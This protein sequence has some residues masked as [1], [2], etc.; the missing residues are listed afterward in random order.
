MQQAEPNKRI[1]YFTTEYPH[2]SHTFI[3]REIVG[4]ETRGYAIERFA[5]KPGEAGV[6]HAD[7]A[8]RD[9]TTYLL[10]QSPARIVAL[11]GKGLALAGLSIL[12]TLMEVLKLARA[13]DRGLARHIAYLGEALLLR[14]LCREKAVPHLHVHFGTNAATIAYFARLMGGPEFSVMV[15][16]PVEFDQ[17]YGQSLGRKLAAARFITAISSYCRSQLYRWLPLDCWQKVHIVPCTVGDDWFEAGQPI[18]PSS[19]NLVSVGRLDEQKGQLILVEAFADAVDAGLTSRLTL[20]GDGPLRAAIEER[21]RQRNIADRVDLTGWL[22]ASEVRNHLL[23][24]R[25][26]VLPSF[27]EGLPV[28]IMEA[29]ATMRPVLASRITGIPELVREGSEGWLITPSD[30]EALC[31]ALL[32]LEA[33]AL[34]ELHAMGASAQSRVRER[35]HTDVA[36]ERL[37]RLFSEGVD[38]S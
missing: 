25:A 15:H 19:S 38:E 22:P 1:G 9:K 10:K 13:S 27:A 30:R 23:A 5:I 36:V 32:S 4:L 8:E 29:M 18:D 24:S 14:A 26:L 31:A 21:L 16:G 34:S 2:I 28:V 11:L 33:A 7:I 35:H 6:E 37:D 12:P 3:R 17:P 20:I